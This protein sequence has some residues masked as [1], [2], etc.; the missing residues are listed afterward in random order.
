[1]AAPSA[2]VVLKVYPPIS[3]ESCAALSEKLLRL[4][5]DR[6]FTAV[7]TDDVAVWSS[8]LT[9]IVGVEG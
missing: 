8:A 1:M 2:M 5:A 3:W 6:A 7:S 9:L 4:S